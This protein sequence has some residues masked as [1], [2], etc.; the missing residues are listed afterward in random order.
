MA[1]MDGIF[2]FRSKNGNLRTLLFAYPQGLLRFAASAA[3]GES[4]ASY[5]LRMQR[6]QKTA[7]NF[8]AS[9][10]K[11]RRSNPNFDVEALVLKYRFA[12]EDCNPCVIHV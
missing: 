11:K 2:E 9:Y 4:N 7:R 10:Y 1:A 3:D 5:L 6:C 12:K 8:L